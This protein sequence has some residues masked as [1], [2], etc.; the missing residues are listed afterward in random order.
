M[1]KVGGEPNGFWEYGGC[2]LGNKSAG[3]TYVISWVLEVLI[4]TSSLLC[5]E[6]PSFLP[7]KNE[8]LLRERELFSTFSL[9][10]IHSG[11]L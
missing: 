9:L 4:T 6:Q 7:R 11:F 8:F 2:Y 10:T 1:V 3:P 5:Y